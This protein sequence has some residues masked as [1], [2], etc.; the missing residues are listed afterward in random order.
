MKASRRLTLLLLA[1][2][3]LPICTARGAEE[4]NG[5]AWIISAHHC[6]KAGC[7]WETPMDITDTTAIWRMLTAPVTVVDGHEKTQVYL[8]REPDAA[9]EPVAEI[10]CGTQDLHVLETLA[11]GWTKV[12][13]YSSSFHDSKIKAW[14]ALA[15]G[16]VPTDSLLVKGVSAK[17][18]LVVDKLTQRLYL[19]R[20]GTLYDTLA[21]STGLPNERQPYNETTSGAFLLSSRVGAFVSGESVCAYGIRFDDGNILHEVPYLPRV[22]GGKYYQFEPELG[23]RASHGCVRVQRKR[24]PLGVNMEWLWTELADQL[25]TKLVI[26]DDP[27]GRSIPYPDDDTLLYWNPQARPR[28]HRAANCYSEG[29]RK[30]PTTAFAYGE[31]ESE[32]YRALEMCTGCF[33]PLRKAEI[34]KINQA[35]AGTENETE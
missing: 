18:G 33:P 24:T 1:L 6:G 20:E 17:Y 14:N 27:A 25:G 22:G 34:D 29:K 19:F 13:T 16:Y 4:Q 10:T 8:Y 2:C 15:E 31:L 23:Q 35:H 5:A 32:P 30:Q 9:S 11:N 28:Y 12:E 3:C 21:V 7:Y 26:W